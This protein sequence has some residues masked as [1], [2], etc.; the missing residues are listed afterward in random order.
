LKS[1]ENY[2]RH[3]AIYEHGVERLV[4]FL[5][6]QPDASVLEPQSSVETVIL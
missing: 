4:L 6:V 2:R 1:T 3:C 5:Q